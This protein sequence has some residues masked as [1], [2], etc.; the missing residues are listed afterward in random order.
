MYAC[1]QVHLHG[2]SIVQNWEWQWSLFP[3]GFVGSVGAPFDNT[4]LAIPVSVEDI[5][6]SISRNNLPTEFHFTVPTH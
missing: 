1:T 2:S 4:E 3:E 5:S 6:E